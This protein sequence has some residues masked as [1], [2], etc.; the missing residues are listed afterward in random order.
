[1]RI[2]SNIHPWIRL[3]TSSEHMLTLLDFLTALPEEVIWNLSNRYLIDW[4]YSGQ[5]IND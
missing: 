5:Y 3:K 2:L 4:I 1:M